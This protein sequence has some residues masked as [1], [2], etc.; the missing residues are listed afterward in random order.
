[1][2][3]SS[4]TQIPAQLGCRSLANVRVRMLPPAKHHGS[5]SRARLNGAWMRL[6][7]RR[8]LMLAK[9]TGGHH[10]KRPAQIPGVRMAGISKLSGF[11]RRLMAPPRL[12]RVAAACV[13]SW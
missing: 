8:A 12:D 10:V 3:C 5:G 9:A 4:S 13:A 7:Q 6:C 2:C 11:S 1:M